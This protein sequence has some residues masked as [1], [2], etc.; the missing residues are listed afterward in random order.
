MAT[1]PSTKIKYSSQEIDNQSF[2]EDYG[3]KLTE[4]LGFDGINL[5]RLNASNL[6]IQIEYDGSN[7]PIYLGFAAPGSLI[8]EE[9]WQIRY[10]TFDVN[11]NVTSMSY[12]DGTPNFDKKWSKRDTDYVYT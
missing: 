3:T 6:N 7:N 2:D 10:L 12:A 1:K 4:G 11:N 5:Q 9:K 8:T